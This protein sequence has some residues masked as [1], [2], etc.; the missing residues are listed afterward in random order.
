L[1][2]PATTGYPIRLPF[3]FFAEDKSLGDN[4]P[5][6]GAA[7]ARAFLGGHLIGYGLF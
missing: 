2:F 5:I 7:L 4:F 3:V 1:A 6:G